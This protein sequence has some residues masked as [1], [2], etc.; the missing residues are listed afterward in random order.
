MSLLGISKERQLFLNICAF[1]I[2]EEHT[3]YVFFITPSSAEI[4]YI[5]N[6]N[7]AP[8]SRTLS[9]LLKD[10]EQEIRLIILFGPY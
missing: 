8:P 5:A 4:L 10:L 7:N 1:S 6:E 9:I 3:A 2:F